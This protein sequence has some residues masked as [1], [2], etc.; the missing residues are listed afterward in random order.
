MTERFTRNLHEWKRPFQPGGNKPTLR[1]QDSASRDL[2]SRYKK[3]GMF[4]NLK[5][6]RR[7]KAV[8]TGETEYGLKKEERHDR[9]DSADDQARKEPVPRQNLQENSQARFYQLDPTTARRNQPVKRRSILRHGKARENLHKPAEIPH[10]G[11]SRRG[12]D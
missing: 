10:K 3:N 6:F 5:A 9:Y 4:L 2:R 7:M 8:T 1:K 12:L 11:R